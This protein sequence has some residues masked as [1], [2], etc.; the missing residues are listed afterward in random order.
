MKPLKP[1]EWI[2]S[3]RDD[4]R[5]FPKE[6]RAVI[7][8][9]LYRAQQG[10]EHPASKALK[11]FGGRGV[12]EIVDDFDGDTFRAVYTVRFSDAV[13]E[14]RTRNAEARDRT[15]TQPSETRRNSPPGRIRKANEMSADIPVHR[16]SGNVFAD[17][18]FDNSEEMQLRADLVQQMREIVARRKLTQMAAAEL[19]GIKQPDLSALLRGRLTKYSLERLLKFMTILDR[20]VKIVVQAKPRHR[21]ARITL[22]VS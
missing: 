5:S 11:G 1:V 22:A 10:G 12:L 21:P 17:L 2:A 19:L 20:D 3:S 18:G 8:E 14:A 9:A 7:G 13:I 16:G 6:V 15:D 4:V